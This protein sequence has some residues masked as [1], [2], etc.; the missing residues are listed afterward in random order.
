MIT[1]CEHLQ[2]IGHS[3]LLAL[4]EI[5]ETKPYIVITDS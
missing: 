1:R 5:L 4:E 3:P 2:L